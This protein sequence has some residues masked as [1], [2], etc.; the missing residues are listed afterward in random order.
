MSTNYYKLKRPI[1]HLELA[2]GDE[3]NCLTVYVNDGLSG[4]L[5]L[6]KSVTGQVVRMFTRYE[7]ALFE[8]W[9]GC[10]VDYVGLSSDTLV[11]SDAGEL[12]TVGQVEARTRGRA[13]SK[14]KFHTGKQV[15]EHYGVHAE[16]PVAPRSPWDV[17]R[18]KEN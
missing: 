10:V 1:T 7:E 6:P 15:L 8:W 13:E 18:E 11:V 2:E 17:G 9:D 14:K 5:V 3:H 4:V 16:K 12:L